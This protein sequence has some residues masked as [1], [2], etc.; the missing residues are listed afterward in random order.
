MLFIDL[1]SVGPDLKKVGSYKYWETARVILIAYAIDDGPVKVLQE[2]NFYDVLPHLFGE[3]CIHNAA[4]DIAGLEKT[5]GIVIDFTKVTDTEALARARGLPGGLDKLSKFFKLDEVVAKKNF[6]GFRERLRDETSGHTLFP[7]AEDRTFLEYA[8]ND[9]SAMRAIYSIFAPSITKDAAALAT[10]NMNRRGFQI[11]T[12][13]ANFFMLRSKS[14]LN[15]LN[16]KIHRISDGR[17]KNARSTAAV[18]KLAASLPPDT[19]QS[20]LDVR[21]AACS[22][23]LAKYNTMLDRVCADGRIRGGF[24]FDGAHTGRMS[25]AGAQPQNLPRPDMS[26][27]EICAFLD[28]TAKNVSDEDFVRYGKS[29]LRGTII[30]KPG[31]K[32]VVGDYS[33][34]EARVLAWLAAEDWK[35]HAFREFDAGRGKDIYIAAYSRAF[36]VPE[37]NVTNEQRQIGKGMELAFGYQ[38]AVGAFRKLNQKFSHWPDS[39]VEKLVSLYRSTNQ[40][41]AGLWRDCESGF[42]SCLHNQTLT[43]ANNSVLRVGLLK[44][45]FDAQMDAICIVLPSGRKLWYRQPQIGQDGRVSYLNN[46]LARVQTY[47]GKLVENIT[48]AVAADILR[49]ALVKA[50]SE[51]LP[52]VMAVHDEIVAEVPCNK[53]GAKA[54]LEVIMKNNNGWHE[55]P[56]AVNTYEG[57][58]YGKD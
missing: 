42:Y 31:H 14:F 8:A 53:I 3:L 19:A 9:V 37:L 44:M 39:E 54:E 41:I 46:R 17:I 12:P 1:E 34:I 25:G 5:F 18:H 21:N 47:G 49:D 2:G 35:L 7:I 52:V 43:A 48:Q 56:L 40:K 58:R 23:S 20:L 36:G 29:C 11:D 28:N 45:Y 13:T 33:A 55:V 15:N 10:Y 51:N 38:G 27:A 26:Y 4:F 16:S 22:T 24:I 30:A 6:S 50:D 57:K 32:L